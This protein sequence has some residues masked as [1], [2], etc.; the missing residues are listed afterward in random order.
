MDEARPQAEADESIGLSLVIVSAPPESMDAVLAFAAALPATLPYPVIL[1]HRLDPV[2]ARELESTL[3]EQSPVPVVP[4]TERTA[5]E[6]GH[7]Y[8]APSDRHLEITGEAG[9]AV[10][11]PVQD[12]SPSVD[13]LIASAA[14]VMTD[15]LIG[16]M[17]TGRGSDGIGAAQA[18]KAYGGT[19]ILQ[20]PASSPFTGLTELLPAASVDVVA[21]L[22]AIVPLIGDLLTGDYPLARMGEAQELRLFLER[23]RSRTGLDFTPYKRPTIERRL[24][25][26]MAAVGAPSLAAY[27]RHIDRNPEELQSLV[28]AFLIKVTDF[29]R[30]VDLYDHL[31]TIV[32]P[33]LIED[34]RTSGSEIRIWSAGCATGEEPYSLAI[35]LAELLDEAG[36]SV[37]VRILA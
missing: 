15:N 23:V 20:D 25:R 11:E 16:V 5:I 3:R 17:L 26:R 37:P 35:L 22:E 4:I 30:D 19:V 7:L 31:R 6:V 24:R 21:E 36:E 29:F 14:R 8:L 2:H 9:E 12:A 32:L 18:I 33:R 34:A 13:R 1:A 27:W 10:A 28:S